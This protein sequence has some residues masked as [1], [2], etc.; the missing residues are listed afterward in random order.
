MSKT[1]YHI[2]VV[3]RTIFIAPQIVESFTDAVMKYNDAIQKMMDLHD[4]KI[5]MR[6]IGITTLTDG[7]TVKYKVCSKGCMENHETG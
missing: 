3:S 4:S 5:V 2:S 6:G 1:H 7:D